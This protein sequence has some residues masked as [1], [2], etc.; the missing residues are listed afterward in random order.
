VLSEDGFIYLL[1]RYTATV[2]KMD[3]DGSVLS[4]KKIGDTSSGQPLITSE[5]RLYHCSTLNDIGTLNKIYYDDIG[6]LPE[7]KWPMYGGN[8]Q[9]SGYVFDSRNL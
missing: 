7:G 4:K 1:T 8:Q 3:S 6:S 9:C 5:G 2:F